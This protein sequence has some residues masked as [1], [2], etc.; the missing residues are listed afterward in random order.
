VQQ[1]RGIQKAILVT[2]DIVTHATAEVDQLGVLVNLQALQ[3]LTSDMSK[4]CFI[5]AIYEILYIYI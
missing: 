4:I 3:N 2:E 1:H 5:H